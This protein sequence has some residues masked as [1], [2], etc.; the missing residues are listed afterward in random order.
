M[1]C[2]TLIIKYVATLSCLYSA[3]RRATL[4]SRVVM[5]SLK[6]DLMFAHPTVNPN[7]TAN[8][9]SNLQKCSRSDK[10]Q[11]STN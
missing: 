2:V 9:D 1:L 4:L 3:N 11:A 10:I 6:R 8:H 7:G 5:V